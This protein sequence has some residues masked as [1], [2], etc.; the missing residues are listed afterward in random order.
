MTK[1]AIIN[2]FLSTGVFVLPLLGA[3]NR[4]AHPGPWLAVV[5]WWIVLMSQPAMKAKEIFDNPQDRR[6]ALCIA[7]AMLLGQSTA[8][9]DFGYGR[10]LL[11]E[12]WPTVA[13]GG[14]LSLAGLALRVWSIRT[15]G[16]FFTTTVG[17]QR[18][19]TVVRCGP[20]RVLRHPSYTGALLNAVGVA[21]MLGSPFGAATTLLLAVPAYL[22]RIACEE[23]LLL[24]ELGKAYASYRQSS[25]RLIPLAF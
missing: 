2:L 8:A 19:Q 10:G 4:L 14:L 12:I 18:G 23:R 7:V 24:A 20:Y 25:W 5:G 11:P 21:V 16:R 13:C 15:L 17:V 3:D 6:S 1:R 9:L 22:Y